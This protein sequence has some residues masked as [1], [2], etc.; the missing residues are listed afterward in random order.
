MY[1]HKLPLWVYGD[2]DGTCRDPLYGQIEWRELHMTKEEGTRLNRL[3]QIEAEI[4]MLFLSADAP[5]A[6]PDDAGDLRAWWWLQNVSE[7]DKATRGDIYERTGFAPRQQPAIRKLTGCVSRARW[8]YVE[9]DTPQAAR[10]LSKERC[11]AMPAKFQG[12]YKL[13]LP[14]QYGYAGGEVEILKAL[15]DERKVQKAS[16]IREKEDIVDGYCTLPAPEL[17]TVADDDAI[18]SVPFIT[19]ALWYTMLDK[20][21]TT[22]DE[23]RGKVVTLAAIEAYLVSLPAPGNLSKSD[24]LPPPADMLRLDDGTEIPF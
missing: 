9:A 22:I 20:G 12:Q 8:R 2:S 23:W 4:D 19:R 13:Q 10:A 6:I 11:Y 5:F 15:D 16:T 3:N 17:P 18:D 7:G 1:G 14:S 24:G 21:T